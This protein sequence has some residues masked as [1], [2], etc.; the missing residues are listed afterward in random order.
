MGW[1]DRYRSAQFRNIKFFVPNAEGRGGRKTVV[2]ELPEKDIPY[3]QD[4]GRSGRR[5]T[6]EAYT[7]GD[8]YDIQRD[9]LLS[10]LEKG[11]SG[12][13]VHPY[14][15]ILDVAILDFSWRETF[16]EMGMCRFQISCIESGALKFPTGIVDTSQAVQV[17]KKTALQELQETFLEVYNVLSV[18]RTITQSAIDTVEKAFSVI[19]G[20]KFAVSAASAFRRD[21]ETLRGKAIALA[22]DGQEL[23]QNIIEA[24][25]FGT[26]QD[27]ATPVTE[28]NARQNFNDMRKLFDFESVPPIRPDL[29][30]PSNEIAALVKQASVINAAGLL[31]VMS[32]ASANEAEELRNI[33]FARLD[34]IME[35]TE[36]DD[37]YEALYELRTRIVDDLAKRI[38]KLP[39]L[40]VHRLPISLPAI[41]VSYDLYGT[42]EREKSIIDRNNISHPA[43]V[44]GSVPLEVLIDA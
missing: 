17:S 1:Q 39:V 3:I 36:D 44:P 28:E 13:L 27:D 34:P 8:D 22:Y 29:G 37:Y 35:E 25:T 18:P 16:R 23:A 21:I 19:E 6:L 11:G 41:V 42:L 33:V 12:K 20:A 40:S 10:A 38:K 43:F 7:I 30:N 31:G 32:Y 15:G 26:N 24:I 4:L 2:H 5:F 9:D 14:L